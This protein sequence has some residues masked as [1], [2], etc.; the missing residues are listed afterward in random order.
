MASDPPTLTG[1]I[2]AIV[3]AASQL[4]RRS[5][6]GKLGESVRRRVRNLLDLPS[7]EELAAAVA[8]IEKM[9][10]RLE[11][12]RAEPSHTPTANAEDGPKLSDVQESLDQV[13]KLKKQ[14]K[15][16]LKGGKKKRKGKG[17]QSSKSTGPTINVGSPKTVKERKSRRSK[18]E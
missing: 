2:L 15:K 17:R 13:R 8:R 10:A 6:F 3:P 11:K 14:L 12:L 9:D 18:S 1:R 4:A 16:E 7:A 5:R